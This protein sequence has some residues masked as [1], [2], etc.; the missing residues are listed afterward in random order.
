MDKRI[1]IAQRELRLREQKIRR[2]LEKLGMNVATIAISPSA[3]LLEDDDPDRSD[4]E[5]KTSKQRL[6]IK[7]PFALRRFASNAVD[8]AAETNHNGYPMAVPSVQESD[9]RT[10][11]FPFTCATLLNSPRSDLNSAND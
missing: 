6:K 1:R 4:G 11:T 10:I 8:A 9:Q 7:L 2:Q 5:L 3:R